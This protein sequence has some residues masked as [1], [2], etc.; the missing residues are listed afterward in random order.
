MIY[1]IKSSS[2]RLLNSKI[3]ELTK[4]L[5]EKKYFNL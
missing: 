3:Q 1:V 5:N 2:F 4:D